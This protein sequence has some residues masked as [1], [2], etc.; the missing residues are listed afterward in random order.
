MTL[1]PVFD[2]LARV[3]PVAVFLIAITVVAELADRA[4]VFDV[5]GHWIARRGGHRMWSLWLLFSIFAVTCTVFLSLDTTAVLLTPVA[6][7]IARQV[8]VAPRPFALTTLWI[9]N[10]GSLLLPVSNLT[11]L[12]ALQRFQAMGVDHA[13]YVRIALL[14]ATVSVVVTLA[15]IAGLHRRQLSTRYAVDPPAEPHDPVL[16][17]IGM[18]GCALVGPA[19]AVG[20]P[21]WAVALAAAAALGLAT[22]WRMPTLLRRLSVPWPMTLGFVALSALVAAAHAAG[23][24]GGVVS[25]AGTGTASA[26]CCA[27]PGSR[28]PPPTSSTT[29]RP[30]SPWS[31]P[32]ATRD[33]CWRCS[34]APTAAPSSPPG[35]HWRL[36]CGCSAVAPPGCAGGCGGS[37]SAG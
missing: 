31:R 9:A 19:F 21:P 3:L 8:G 10:T 27:P 7:A 20:L 1:T 23:L 22:A 32:A 36:C 37:R 35:P 13:A 25:L 28:R 4:G 24:L 12:L 11:N 5:A 33:G 16:L 17:R 29:C 18:L 2:E 14:P 34:S 30:T 15:V 26:T 6:L